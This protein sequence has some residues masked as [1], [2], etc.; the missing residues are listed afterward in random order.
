M[1]S[2]KFKHFQNKLTRYSR[3]SSLHIFYALYRNK[4]PLSKI[5]SRLL[6]MISKWFIINLLARV[7]LA[8]CYEVNR[9]YYDVRYRNSMGL[10]FVSEVLRLYKGPI[11][12]SGLITAHFKIFNTQSQTNLYKLLCTCLIPL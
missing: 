4:E 5:I 6:R 1:F 2:K 3:Y 8:T 7:K 12:K 10:K 11:A 9:N